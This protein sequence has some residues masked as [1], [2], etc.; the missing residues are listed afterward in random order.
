MSLPFFAS[1]KKNAPDATIVCLTRQH[2]VPLFACAEGVDRVLPLDE[3]AGRSGW[4]SQWRNATILRREKFDLGFCLPP[5]F[6]SALM[7]WLAR[8]PRRVGHAADGRRFLLTD[9]L[10]YGRN[11]SRPHRT[12]GYQALLDLVWP[13]PV[14]ERDLRYVPGEA[15]QHA[16]DGLWER[17]GLDQAARILAI[18][19]GAAQPNKLWP[20]ERFAEV[21]RR[22]IATPGG[23]VII[24]GAAG[25]QTI[26]AAVAQAARER[27]V[28]NFNGAGD[29][30]IAAEIIRRAHLFVGNDSG[31]S[32]LA[33]AVGTPTVV[34]SGPGDPGE[35]APYSPYALTVKKPLF[36]SPCYRNVC[37]RRD[38]PLECQDLVNVD[39]V[40]EAA[41]TL[42]QRTDY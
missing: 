2:L 26:C 17:S 42:R 22:W 21:A 9:S 25:E 8:I 33:A 24:V 12:D 13:N 32:H 16:V 27:N 28:F 4:R 15:A 29:L 38:K 41:A 34:I 18:G 19:P 5:S 31:L 14:R 6:G 1:L 30:T 3:T 11:G 39:D 36:C 35:V 23:T 20:S 10:P 7:L 37:W 40:W